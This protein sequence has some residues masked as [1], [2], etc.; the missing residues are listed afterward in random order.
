ME[1]QNGAVKKSPYIMK[2]NPTASKTIQLSNLTEL[3]YYLYFL[4]KPFYLKPSGM[5]QMADVCLAIAGILYF[6]ECLVQGKNKNFKIIYYFYLFIAY[7][8]VVNTV[9]MIK[10]QD[11]GF[12]ISTA[13]W[14]FNLLFLILSYRMIGEK[15]SLKGV[16]FIFKVTIFVQFVIYIF[17][18]GRWCGKVRYMGSFNDPNQFAFYLLMC[19]L[20]I[21]IYEMYVGFSMS[22]CLCIGMVV[23]LVIKSMSRGVSLGVILVVFFELLNG[24]YKFYKKN[25]ISVARKKLLY[26]LAGLMLLSIVLFVGMHFRGTSGSYTIWSRWAATLS[27]VKEG[28]GL[29]S[30]GINAFEERG[31][32]R[33]WKYPEYWLLG[34]GEGGYGRF[35]T[36]Y[37]GEMHS[38]F[39]GILFCYGFVPFLLI[40]LW[41]FYSI[42]NLDGK[43][44]AVYAALIIESCTL[45]HYRQPVFWLIFVIGWCIQNNKP[46]LLK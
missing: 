28:K 6:V 17:R 42:K 15:D 44:M 24:L 21:L 46:S 20:S 1:K 45:V 31:I 11:T 10:L 9:Y 8:V 36:L 3:F 30:N 5:I 2:W 38:T 32:D 35:A 16:V 37:K 39:P 41:C 33:V 29:T 22:G 7:V 14:I 27:S 12:L 25:K 43:Y 4:L 13:Y 18:L 34:A 19:A 40:L 26:F 23:F